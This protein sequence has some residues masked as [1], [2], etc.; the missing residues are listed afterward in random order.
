MKLRL[1]NPSGNILLGWFLALYTASAFGVSE[2][3]WAKLIKKGDPN[4]LVAAIREKGPDYRVDSELFQRLCNHPALI[5]AVLDYLQD[6][7]EQELQ[8]ISEADPSQTV[9]IR[10]PSRAVAEK[11]LPDKDLVS[12]K[13]RELL[14]E[15][16]VSQKLQGSAGSL[17]NMQTREFLTRIIM[18]LGQEADL[19]GY[20]QAPSWVR[21]MSERAG[22]AK[23]KGF[24]KLKFSV[25][26]VSF[27]GLERENGVRVY[28][29]LFMVSHRPQD[30]GFFNL[31]D[32]FLLSH[33]AFPVKY[34]AE[35]G[36]FQLSPIGK[37]SRTVLRLGKIL[38]RMK[39]LDLFPGIWG[40]RVRHT[41]GNGD[42]RSEQTHYFQVDAG[43][44]YQLVIRDSDKALRFELKQ[45]N[46]K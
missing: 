45:G 1:A 39:S 23:S 10:P 46:A 43:H 24:S 41:T 15:L 32:A 3:D 28:I 18:D 33:E 26:K 29:G 22:K 27:S 9:T 16:L 5:Q 40:F 8:G 21:E 44:E 35:D 2:P 7:Y 11:P 37:P 6:G 38:N 19:S 31:E 36:S 17:K 4:Q 12:R 13:V 34:I 42:L 30:T 20:P 14:D 25:D